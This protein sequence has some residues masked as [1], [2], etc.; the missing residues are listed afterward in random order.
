LKKWAVTQEVRVLQRY[1][2]A[3]ETLQS[4]RATLVCA[5]RASTLQ[6]IL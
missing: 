6:A 4:P 3:G 2:A 5:L 1:W